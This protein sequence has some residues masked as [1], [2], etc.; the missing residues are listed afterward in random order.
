MISENSNLSC[1]DPPSFLD[2]I[3]DQKDHIAMA[4]MRTAGQQYSDNSKDKPRVMCQETRVNVMT[5]LIPISHIG[6]IIQ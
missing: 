3:S 4:M 1:K 5:A 6:N 2:G